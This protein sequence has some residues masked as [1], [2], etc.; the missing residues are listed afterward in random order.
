[1]TRSCHVN[2]PLLVAS[3]AP[4]Y[5]LVLLSPDF[6][7]LLAVEFLRHMEPPMPISVLSSSTAG[8]SADGEDEDGNGYG[9]SSNPVG[10]LA[11]LSGGGFGG[12]SSGEGHSGLGS[13]TEAGRAVEAGVDL[14]TNV[15]KL[16]P[17]I[18]CAYIELA[19]CHMAQGMYEE[20]SRVLHQCLA[21]QPHCS[22]AL[23]ALAKVE[24]LRMNASA[25]DRSLEHALSCDFSVRSVHLFR[26]VQATV[27]AQQGR[28]DE[29]IKEI[30]ALMALPEIQQGPSY[31]ASSGAHDEPDAFRGMGVKPKIG[32]DGTSSGSS[33]GSGTMHTDSLRLTE[34]DRVGAFIVYASL[35]SKARRLKEGNK[36]LSEAKMA[37]A[38]TPQE[39]QVLVAAS[40]LAVERKDFDT[41]IRTLDKIAPDNPTYKRA[42]MIKAEVY[43]VYQR[44]KEKFVNCYNQL[45]SRDGS[46]QNY[47]L[48]GEAY[49]RILN[50]EKAVEALEVGYT[51]DLTQPFSLINLTE[52]NPFPI[53]G[54]LQDGS[55][56]Q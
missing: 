49:L 8:M 25:A 41:A 14:L 28:A 23:V 19:R 21:L 55:V 2:D 15:L 56:E 7:T 51:M 9:N 31:R 53:S 44:D 13:N 54:G 40:H 11:A 22:A 50:P 42:Q 12:S 34:D 29:A 16:C 32:K 47:A 26:L 38:G 37:F 39:V 35:L 36:V 27:R 24:V 5:D 1:M 30:E 6:M 10:G 3:Q 18:M 43:L 48:L 52:T 45:V 20:A 17:G 33:S 46:S 4:F